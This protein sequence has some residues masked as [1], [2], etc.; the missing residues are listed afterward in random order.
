MIRNNGLE[1]TVNKKLATNDINLDW[2]S[3]PPTSWKQVRTL[4]TI[5]RTF[6]VCS[7]SEYLLKELDHILCVFKNYSN[8]PKWIL[9]Q[10]EKEKL[11]QHDIVNPSLATTENNIEKCHLLVLPYAGPKHDKLITS[12]KK[13]LK[14]N[15]PES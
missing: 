12:L 11:N 9:K 2:K 10:L 6:L 14:I 4:K 8:F 13:S 3:F 15:L 7:K 1:T 5:S